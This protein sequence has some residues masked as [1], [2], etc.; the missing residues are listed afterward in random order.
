M[1]TGDNEIPGVFQEYRENIQ[2]PGQKLKIPGISRNSRNSEHYVLFRKN[3]I[4]EKIQYKK[5][6]LNNVCKL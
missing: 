2:D 1:V 6:S 5:T 4:A 3:V